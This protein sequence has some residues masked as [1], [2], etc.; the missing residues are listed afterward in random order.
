MITL[1][2]IDINDPKLKRTA[3]LAKALGHP[4]RIAILR[5]LSERNTCICGDI[6][7]VLPLA[8]STVSQHLKALKT[9]GL[10]KGEV[11]GVRTCYCLDP[12][13]VD[14]LNELLAGFSKNLIT[15]YNKNCC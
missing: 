12:D 6:T 13:G 2:P 8:Q 14:E 11:E 3:E 5:L 10:I 9:A 1:A 15:L 7:D 4:A